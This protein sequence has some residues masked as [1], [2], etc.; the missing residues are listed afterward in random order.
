MLYDNTRQI[1][2]ITGTSVRCNCHS[3][4]EPGVD[5]GARWR[6]GE[7]GLW[8]P[9]RDISQ[10]ATTS[11]ARGASQDTSEN[12]SATAHEIIS[13]IYPLSSIQFLLH[14]NTNVIM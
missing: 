3:D 11:Q 6:A 14:Q 1:V 7:Q 10:C 5:T 4:T 12:N 2:T 8:S 13:S 9:D